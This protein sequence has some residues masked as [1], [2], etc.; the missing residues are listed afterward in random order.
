MKNIRKKKTN[1][2]NWAIGRRC[3]TKLLINSRQ[4]E[5]RREKDEGKIEEKNQTKNKNPETMNPFWAFEV[6][7]KRA[8]DGN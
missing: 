2:T 7:K 5:R 8:L 3:A 1:K 4:D 6:V